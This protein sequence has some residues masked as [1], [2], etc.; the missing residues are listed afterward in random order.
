MVQSRPQSSIAVTGILVVIVFA[1]FSKLVGG[2]FA[3]GTCKG[4]KF[5]IGPQKN[6]ILCHY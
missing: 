6:R 2:M 4:A 3:H 1:G 5:T